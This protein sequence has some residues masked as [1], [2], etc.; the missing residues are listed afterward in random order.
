FAGDEFNGLFSQIPGEQK[1]VQ[2]IR[3]RRG[4]AKREYRV[5]AEENSDRHPL[6]GFVISTAMPGG[7]F[8]ELPVHPGGLG[9]VDLNAIHSEITVAGVRVA[10]DDAWE[11]D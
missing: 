7:D 8:L 11:G 10:R 1:F 5:A 4:G 6:A 2:P 3:Q 9:V